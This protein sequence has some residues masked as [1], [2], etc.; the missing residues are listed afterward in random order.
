MAKF[1]ERQALDNIMLNIRK[2]RDELGLYM[3]GFATI[4]GRTVIKL[5]QKNSND[6]N[7]SCLGFSLDENGELKM[8]LI[9][10]STNSDIIEPMSLPTDLAMTCDLY[11]F[12]CGGIECLWH[13]EGGFYF[14]GDD[15]KT[16]WELVE[17]Y[18]NVMMRATNG[19]HHD[20]DYLIRFG[21]GHNLNIREHNGRYA[22]W[23]L[24]DSRYCE[25]PTNEERIK[26]I[27]EYIYKGAF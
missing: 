24:E 5:V 8:H 17:E 27:R 2:V 25:K 21:Y 12:M 23:E 3:S 22:M 14:K 13:Y 16:Q 6:I 20:A 1:D 4:N 19:R 15:A 26:M 18:Y 7:H 10:M 9:E 11:S